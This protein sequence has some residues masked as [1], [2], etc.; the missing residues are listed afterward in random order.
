MKFDSIES[1][2]FLVFHQT[3]T[4]RGAVRLPKNCTEERTSL[5]FRFLLIPKERPVPQMVPMNRLVWLER[6]ALACIIFDAPNSRVDN[7][8]LLGALT[9]KL[10]CLK[11]LY[12]SC[13]S[14]CVQQYA[15]DSDD[16]S[17]VLFSDLLANDE[18]LEDFHPLGSVESYAPDSLTDLFK[19]LLV[20]S[21]EKQ[22]YM[23]LITLH[24][25]R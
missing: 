5:D 12:E 24:K 1:D 9:R 21:V 14:F 13:R 22:F 25:M 11:N 8:V 3:T 23:E 20:H 4:H 18:R 16:G 19:F 2:E 15:R 6:M 17:M 7:L 10:K